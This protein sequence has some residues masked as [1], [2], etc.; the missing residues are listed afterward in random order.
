MQFPTTTTASALLLFA[1]L[2]ASKITLPETMDSSVPAEPD[3]T[4]QITDSDYPISSCDQGNDG[5]ICNGFDGLC[6]FRASGSVQRNSKAVD[7]KNKDLCKD[8]LIGT[9]CLQRAQ[10][11]QPS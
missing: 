10:C 2:V 8:Q 9:S 1:S 11:C 6:R 3:C 4:I 5:L 7:D